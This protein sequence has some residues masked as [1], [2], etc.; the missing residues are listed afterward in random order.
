MQLTKNFNLSEFKCKDGT[1]VPYYLQ[2]TVKELAENLQVLR[3][4]VG[5]PITINSA[6]RTASHNRKI[7]G[8]IN[9]QHLIGKAA[10]IVIPGMTSS[11]VYAAITALI[12]AG[13]MKQGGIGYYRNFVHYDIR[14][15]YARW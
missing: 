8:A 5:K 6:Y 1:A 9:S 7:G 4:H 15:W 3:D 12:R 11:Q 14:G 2:N 13:K 10:D